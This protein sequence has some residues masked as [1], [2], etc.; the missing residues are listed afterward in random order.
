MKD[1]FTPDGARR[2]MI[3]AVEPTT[4]ETLLTRIAETLE[5]MEFDQRELLITIKE[6]S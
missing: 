4:V 1:C 5:R 3:E 2:V 6:R